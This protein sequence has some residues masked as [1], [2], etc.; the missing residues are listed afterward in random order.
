MAATAGA[1]RTSR[2]SRTRLPRPVL[3]VCALLLVVACSADEG[4]GSEPT[5]STTDT[6]TDTTAKDA[7][8]PPATTTAPSP[9][10]SRTTSPEQTEPPAPA[11]PV[12]AETIATGLTTPWGLAF[13]PDG[14]ALVSERDT[15]AIKLV[16][17]GQPPREVGTVPDVVPSS[18]G[19]L[20]GI[21]V[22]PTFPDDPYVY[23][24]QSTGTDN[25]VVRMPYEDETLGPPEMVLDGIPA[26]FIH[27]GGRIAFG[28]DDMLYVSTGDANESSR[29]QD[30]DTLA[31]KILRITADG[32]PAPD[33]PTD[34][35]E[36]WSLGHRNVQG[37]AW[38][39]DD[40]LWASE[41]GSDEWDELNLIEPGENYG[42]PEVEGR[43]G[44]SDY[45]DP[46]AQWPTPDASPSGLAYAS[47]SLWMASLNGERLWRI[48]PDG[49]GGVDEPAAF[50]VGEY[51]RLRTVAAAPDGSLWLTTSNTDGRGDPDDDDD[52]ILRLDLQ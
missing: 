44:G 17:G 7:S 31:G 9:D 48:T 22:T 6:T 10:P 37:L 45:R 16:A 30:P 5:P 38:D 27:D 40:R 42:W 47:G 35:S 43:G 26:S 11:T 50:F 19:G 36:V 14:S 51:G 24:Y 2:G 34:G 39:D 12:V 18:E 8:D 3:A 1:S 21:A 49:S 33:N 4:S 13:L 23:A 28:P 32:D 46:L 52:R 15:G 29:S 41:F 25:Q 20:L